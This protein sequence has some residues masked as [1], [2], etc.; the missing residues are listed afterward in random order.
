MWIKST[1][2]EAQV[3]SVWH[4][5]DDDTKK[6]GDWV[7]KFLGQ[8]VY[9]HILNCNLKQREF[10]LPQSSGASSI[11]LQTLLMIQALRPDRVPAAATQYVHAVFGND[12]LASSD[13]ELDLPTIVEDE[14]KVT[15]FTLLIA[16]IT[17]SYVV[18]RSIWF[19]MRN[20][21]VVSVD[22]LVFG[23]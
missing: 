19:I 17:I 2:P 5:S 9:T 14:I 13:Q 3:P 10:L 20:S 18:D 23:S 1:A 15:K 8:K 7:I 12:F 22:P 21:L 6:V 4:K 11:A 16:S